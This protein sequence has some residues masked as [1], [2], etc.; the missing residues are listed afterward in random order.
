VL[1]ARS[2]LRSLS[3]ALEYSA[4]SPT[5]LRTV[6]AP[7]FGLG[8]IHTDPGSLSLDAVRRVLVL[9]L[10]EIGD[11]IL[12]SPLLRELRRALPSSEIDLVVKREHVG[13]VDA[14]PHVNHVIGMSVSKH[15]HLGRFHR[16]R[17]A[18]ATARSLYR[19]R[20]D[21]ALVP[22]WDSDYFYNA[23]AVAYLVGARWRVGQRERDE[24]NVSSNAL[25]T[26][27]VDDPTP[28]HEVERNLDVLRELH[29][30]PADSRLECWVNERDDRAASEWL[31]HAAME[32]DRLR[33]AVAPS[34][35][36]PRKR[37]PGENFCQLV[38]WLQSVGASVILIGGP[39]DTDI[40]RSIESA[41]PSRLLNVVGKTTLG[42]AI[43]LIRRANL[44]VGNDSGPLHMAASGGVAT[45]AVWC[46]PLSGSHS[47][48]HSPTR[49]G[50]WRNE[51]LVLQP[52]SAL[53]PCGDTCTAAGA[54]CIRQV[55]LG[56]VIEAVSALLPQVRGANAARPS[57][58]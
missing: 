16:Q 49:F 12:T 44:F 48:A 51:S 23:A 11:L 55:S 47:H 35:S 13:L 33:V 56:D 36:H 39:D 1:A 42:A 34:A 58:G 40:A 31:N 6:V 22:R 50:P 54:H 46:H 29:I 9:R 10:D 53:T 25:F 43:A 8:P 7:A 21:L 17:A 28:K 14:C 4:T 5:V 19:Q 24:R 41:A 37:W 38:A 26:H 2:V 27:L 32:H 30:A 45:V 57:F 52:A 20:Y 18:I 3:R 15:D